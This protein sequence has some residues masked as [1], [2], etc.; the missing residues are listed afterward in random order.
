MGAWLG[1]PKRFNLA[2]RFHWLNNSANQS[3]TP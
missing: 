3:G 1:I 2:I